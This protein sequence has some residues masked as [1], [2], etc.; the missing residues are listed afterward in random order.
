MVFFKKTLIATTLLMSMSQ[1]HAGIVTNE[2]ELLGG[3]D[4]EL[5]STM[6]GQ[7]MDLTRIFDKQTGNTSATWHSAVDN[8]GATFTVFE[9]VNAGMAT[10][11]VG[12]YNGASWSLG[13]ST[14]YGYSAS[15]FLFNLDTGQQYLQNGRNG[16]EYSFVSWPGYGPT[17]GAGHDLY[18]NNALDGGGA[19]IGYTYGSML[20]YAQ[21][22]YR[23]EFTGTHN[24]WSV[25]KMETYTL[26]E[27]TGDFGTGAVSSVYTAGNAV[28]NVSVP[29][30]LSAIS[31]VGL[32]G[33]RRKN[34]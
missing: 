18:V 8:Q 4:H 30:A 22:N 19:N 2:S 11:R 34:R 16:T 17:F 6:L 32:M 25:G 26:S 21:T 15:A 10:M 33:L 31:L 14:P 24:A 20:S 1:A 23:N 12:G 9:V 13:Q 29:V 7:D 27:A 3:A 28:A 5:L